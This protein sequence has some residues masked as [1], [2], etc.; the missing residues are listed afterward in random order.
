MSQSQDATQTG[1][2]HSLV[3][4][5]DEQNKVAWTTCRTCRYRSDAEPWEPLTGDDLQAFLDDFNARRA[6]DARLA[7]TTADDAQ[8]GGH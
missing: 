5:E 3:R 1:H 6:A 8:E 7:E 4:V 2:E